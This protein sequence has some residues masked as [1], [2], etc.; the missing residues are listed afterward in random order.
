MIAKKTPSQVS[1]DNDR[2]TLRDYGLLAAAVLALWVTGGGRLAN[3]DE[4]VLA[5]AASA[6]SSEKEPGNL[7][8]RTW[9]DKSG[10]FSVEAEL[11]EVRDDKV[12]LRRGDGT[13][14]AVPTD[15]LSD[16][17]RRYLAS[18]KPA[19]PGGGGLTLIKDGAPTSLI[20]TNGRPKDHITLAVT[21]L[22]EH[23]RLMTGVTLDVVKENEMPTRR[24]GVLILVGPSNRVKERGVNTKELEPESF[25]VKT[26]DDALILVGEDATGS[27]PRT[28]T[29]W[30]VYDFL[31]DEL[32]CRW[33]WPGEIGR[34]VPRTS[35]VAVRSLDIRETPTIKIRGFRMAAQ[36]KHRVAYE[37][38]GLGRLFDLGETY[39]R[40]SED[41]RV[42]LRRMRMGRSFKL[43]YGHA[44]TDWWDEHKDAH[45][46]VFALQPNGRRGPRKSSKPDFVKMCVS[47]PKLWE[48]QLEPLRK[49]AQQGERWQWINACE[50]DGS[51]GFC[52][53]SRCR[54]W[55]ADRNKGLASL[56]AVEDGS[57]VDAQAADNADLPE[58][59][60]DRYA[61]WYNELARRASEADPEARVIAYAYSRYRSPPTNLDRIEPNVWI[62]YV[63]FNAYPRPEAYHKTSVDE[64]F[65]WSRLGATVFLRSNSMFYCG[66]GAPYVVTRQLAED[67][68]F[69]VK[70][71][72]RATDFD[73]LQGYWA[74]TGPSYY[75]L[76]R[77]LWDT[78]ADPGQVL[79]EFYGSFG[80][81][82]G[83]VKEYYD[84]WEEFTERLGND[85]AFFDLRRNER[86]QSYREVYS[87]DVLSKAEA[88]LEK[89]E[90]LLPQATEEEQER[91]VNVELG[92][93][94]GRLLAEALRDGKTSNGPEGERLMTF[95]R[96]VAHRNVINVYWTTSKEIRYRVF[97]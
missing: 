42:W 94:H 72:L 41:E 87:E 53:C 21:E 73:N 57:D 46:D 3:A 96:E 13:V 34:V 70:N 33:I 14:V 61:R 17:D 4:A 22:R 40:I 85:P 86:L 48:M 62:G 76:A 1:A 81:M 9:T 52:V 39:D 12:H 15:R 58:S 68:Q 50:N 64:W 25:V 71:G 38:E 24:P 7:G 78:D 82:E 45:P 10:Q 65:G 84:Y 77:M 92:L 80:P 28:G 43:S 16:R 66:E 55:D 54:A 19:E 20:V 44:F 59:L 89:A 11:V 32:G 37:K 29:L 23:L 2:P 95:R 90:S 75:V 83:V 31:Q 18:L 36:E 97:D 27:N 79:G 60:S 47:N 67:L 51:G 63:G 30:A 49:R 74:T 35:T 56:P 93:E 88:I 8:A 69:Q 5:S 26:T 6:T 91:F